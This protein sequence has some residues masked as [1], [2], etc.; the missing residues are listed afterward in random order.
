MS[1]LSWFIIKR[2]LKCFGYT[3]IQSHYYQTYPTWLVGLSNQI[4]SGCSKIE[5]LLSILHRRKLWKVYLVIPGWISFCSSFFT[6]KTRSRGNS[7]K[8]WKRQI[9]E[10]CVRKDL[11][12]HLMLSLLFSDEKT[13]D[14][15]LSKCPILQSLLMLELEL[16]HRTL[17]TSS[18]TFLPLSH[19]QQHAL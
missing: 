4:K 17:Q 13:E 11:K 7:E 18:H 16:K 3:L 12:D 9:T 15:R 1:S 19:S 8:G 6:E 2:P 14:Q 10:L 5:L